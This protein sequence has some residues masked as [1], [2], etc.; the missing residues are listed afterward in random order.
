MKILMKLLATQIKKGHKV[1]QLKK[2]KSIS[3]NRSRKKML[4]ILRLTFGIDFKYSA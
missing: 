2:S 3:D 4:F 1:M